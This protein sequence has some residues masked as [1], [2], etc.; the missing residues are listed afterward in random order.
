MSPPPLLL[1]DRKDLASNSSGSELDCFDYNPETCK[2]YV[3]D[4][5]MR[6]VHNN[7]NFRKVANSQRR[8]SV[9][10]NAQDSFQ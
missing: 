1:F 3:N 10:K 6:N 4:S 5:T 7:S 8:S 9:K 2:I